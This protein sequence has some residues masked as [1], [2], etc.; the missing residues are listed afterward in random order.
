MKFSHS[1]TLDKIKRER[2][3]CPILSKLKYKF[4]HSP[5]ALRQSHLFRIEIDEN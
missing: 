5:P 3:A 1:L 2:I 4:C